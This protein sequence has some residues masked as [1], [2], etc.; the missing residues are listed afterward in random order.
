MSLSSLVLAV[1]VEERRRS[2]ARDFAF[3]RRFRLRRRVAIAIGALASA[4][5]ALAV[6]VDDEPR[7]QGTISA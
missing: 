1:L 6:A 2:C 4:A 3:A 7:S 5:S